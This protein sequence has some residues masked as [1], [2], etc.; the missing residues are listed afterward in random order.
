VTELSLDNS[1]GT[2]QL[3]KEQYYIQ[4]GLQYDIL[5]YDIQY[6]LQCDMILYDTI[7]TIQYNTT[8]QLYC[9]SHIT[10]LL[11]H[12][13]LILEVKK[14]HIVL[15]VFY[16]GRREMQRQTS[17]CSTSLTLRDT[18]QRLLPST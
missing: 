9:I 7:V 4:Y 6:D 2:L 13:N 16:A 8:I 10:L 14:N 18:M 1:K 15:C 12:S 3:I 11:F 5:P 17:T